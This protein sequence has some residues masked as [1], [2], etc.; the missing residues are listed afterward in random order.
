M[1]KTPDEIREMYKQLEHEIKSRITEQKLPYE[2][3][4]LQASFEELQTS[5]KFFEKYL[6]N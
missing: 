2:R 6:K 4:C 1:L 3:L 5:K